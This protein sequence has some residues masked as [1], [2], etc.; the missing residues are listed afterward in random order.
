M[1]KTPGP[2]KPRFAILACRSLELEMRA[3]AVE[4]GVPFFMRVFSSRCHR[5]PEGLGRAIE[6]SFG[7]IETNLPVFLA[8]GNCFSPVNAGV[9][10]IQGLSALNCAAALL[11][12]N[13]EYERLAEASYFLTPHLAAG[14]KKYFLG[15]ADAVPDKNIKRRLSKYFAPIDKFILID[16]GVRD[17]SPVVASAR[18]LSEIVE[19]PLLGVRG[20]LDL[21]RRDLNDFHAKGF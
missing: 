6:K 12:G 21:L 13:D 18:E 16:S 9:R 8:Y 19:K 4:S 11:G 15:T 3:V 10:K 7:S 1:V 5:D 14:W 20:T 17:L 2:Q